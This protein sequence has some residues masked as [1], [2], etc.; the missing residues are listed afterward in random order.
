MINPVFTNSAGMD[1]SILEKYIKLPQPE[2]K[3]MVTYVWIDGTG[4]NL[5]GILNSILWIMDR[6]LNSDCS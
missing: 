2:G 4:E 5:R 3:T 6:A 1:K